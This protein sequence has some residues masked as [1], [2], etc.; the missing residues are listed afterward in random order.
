MIIFFL[1]H[2]EVYFENKIYKSLLKKYERSNEISNALLK[3]I[4]EKKVYDLIEKFKETKQKD[5]FSEA[6]NS[7]ITLL[8]EIENKRLKDGFILTKDNKN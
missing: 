4:D 2:N 3:V 5:G 1:L 8:N 7:P 6:L